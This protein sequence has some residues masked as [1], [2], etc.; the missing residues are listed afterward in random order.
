[1]REPFEFQVLHSPVEAMSIN[2]DHF[3][4]SFNHQ[5]AEAYPIVVA[6]REGELRAYA[7]LERRTIITPAVSPLA[8][9]PRDTLEVSLA[10]F[11][12]MR[13]MRPGFLI[14]RNLD[15]EPQFT[16]RLVQKMG[17]QRWPYVLYSAVD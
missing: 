4:Q 6:R 2:L 10:F 3:A 11:S 1:M 7:Q 8:N 14:Q 12:L 5:V 15:K 17:I 9:S 13:Q 16:D